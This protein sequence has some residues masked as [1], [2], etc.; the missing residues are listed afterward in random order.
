VPVC[1]Q[2]LAFAGAGV[3]EAVEADADD[4]GDV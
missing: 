1:G 3:G 4:V 2:W